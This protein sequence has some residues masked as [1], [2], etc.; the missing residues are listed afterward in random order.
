MEHLGSEAERSGTQP[1]RLMHPNAGSA[2]TDELIGGFGLSG[3]CV[4]L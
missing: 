1:K 2:M 3:R 4:A